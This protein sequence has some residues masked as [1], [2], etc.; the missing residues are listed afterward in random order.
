MSVKFISVPRSLLA[1]A[2]ASCALAGAGIE[3]AHAVD[4]KV[5]PGSM[6]VRHSGPSLGLEPLNNSAMQN[7]SATDRMGVDCPIVKEGVNTGIALGQVTVVDLN[8]SQALTCRLCTSNRV[9]VDLIF[10]CSDLQRSVIGQRAVQFLTFRAQAGFATGRPHWFF[11]CSIPP[12][13][14]GARSEVFNYYV[15]EQ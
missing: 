12:T 13:E 9:G 7:P 4:D 3:L 11:S 6:C 1:G 5:F 8:Q 14:A 15:D 2:L 10:R